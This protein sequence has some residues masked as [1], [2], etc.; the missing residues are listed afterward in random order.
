MV[1]DIGSWSLFLATWS[2]RMSLYVSSRLL[3]TALSIRLLANVEGDVP[4]LDHVSDLAL[5]RDGEEDAEVDQENG[6]EDRYVKEPEQCASK[7]NYNRPCCRVPIV[8]WK[9]NSNGWVFGMVVFVI[10]LFGEV[11]TAVG[12]GVMFFLDPYPVMAWHTRDVLRGGCSV[13]PHHRH[14][15]ARY[16]APARIFENAGNVCVPYVWFQLFLLF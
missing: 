11:E 14:T 9:I 8:F 3:E 5:H 15:H 13:A 7:R 4:I 12:G 16:P 2:C 6:P 10:G 1:A